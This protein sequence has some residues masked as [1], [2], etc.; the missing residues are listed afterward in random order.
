[1]KL[2][3]LIIDDNAVIHFL[4]SEIVSD[5]G[6][7]QEPFTFFHGKEALQYLNNQQENDNAYFVLLD[8]NMPVMNGWQFLDEIQNYSYKSRIYVII[9][10]SSVDASDKIKAKQYS[11]VIGYFE[12]PISEDDCE[13]I[14]Q[15]AELRPFFS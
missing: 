5:G 1:M 9:V 12:K 11:Q 15:T 3:T 8:L 14:K 6:I 10:S 13:A 2:Q 7:S 4:H